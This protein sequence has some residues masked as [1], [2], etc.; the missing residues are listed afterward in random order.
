VVGLIADAADVAAIG[1]ATIDAAQHGLDQARNDPGLAYCYWLLTQ[2]VLA[3]RQHDFGQALR[4]AGIHTPADPG[5]FDLVASFTDAVDARLRAT[6]VRTDFGE[7]AQL[8]CVG[9]LTELLGGRS[10]SLFGTTA[11]EVKQA[12]RDLSTRDG[13]ANLAHDFFSRFT[14]RFLAYHLGRELSQHVGGNGRFPDPNEHNAFTGH[15]ET[16][17][18][19]AALIVKIFAGDWYSKH[20]FE[21]G[22][23]LRKARGFVSHALGKLASELQRRGARHGA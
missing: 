23:T 16:H 8:A 15:L 10:A 21:G 2:T 18:R 22:I 19:E 11:V 9:S 3:A 17:C 1:G 5:V 20:N 12:A 13:F 6:G 7:M 4:G 14:Y